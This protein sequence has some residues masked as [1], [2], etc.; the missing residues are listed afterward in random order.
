MTSWNRWIT[1]Q[2]HPHGKSARMLTGSLSPVITLI[3]KA[4]QG[5]IPVF[6]KLEGFY[7]EQ[8][9]IDLVPA[10]QLAAMNPS[11]EPYRTAADRGAFVV[12]VLQ[13]DIHEGIYTPLQ[14]RFFD[15][16]TEARDV[17]T[18]LVVDNPGAA[19][20]DFVSDPTGASGAPPS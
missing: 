11:N 10:A 1:G 7:T 17:Y 15:V 5:S 9:R 8:L 20:F 16:L 2:P 4:Q 19:S 13:G 18:A 12:S 14:E 3:H 6:E